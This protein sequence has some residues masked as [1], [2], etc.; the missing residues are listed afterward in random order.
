MNIESGFQPFSLI[1]LM[2]PL[3][4]YKEAYDKKREESLQLDETLGLL[5]N[6]LNSTKEPDSYNRVKSYIDNLSNWSDDFSKGMTMQNSSALYDLHRQYNKEIIPVQNAVA[7]LRELED[8]QREALLKDPSLFFER[9]PTTDISID[10]LKMNPNYDYGAV[11]SGNDIYNKAKDIYGAFSE[12]IRQNPGNWSKILEGQYFQTT[13]RTGA[14]L[15]EVMQA[16]C[17]KNVPDFL[18]APK[19]ELLKAYGIDRFKPADQDRILSEIISATPFALGDTSIETLKNEAWQPVL[20]QQEVPESPTAI[21]DTGE[22]RDLQKP[23]SYYYKTFLPGNSYSMNESNKPE[24]TNVCIERAFSGQG[25]DY[26]LLLESGKKLSDQ[27]RA[28]ISTIINNNKD[29]KTFRM[30][31]LPKLGMDPALL[32]RLVTAMNETLQSDKFSTDKIR[33]SYKR[34][35]VTDT[36]SIKL[37]TNRMGDKIYFYDLDNNGKMT[38]QAPKE[39][40]SKKDLQDNYDFVEIGYS[41]DGQS[42]AVWQDKNNNGKKVYTNPPSFS[43]EDTQYMGQL[44]QSISEANTKIKVLDTLIQKKQTNQEFTAQEKRSLDNYIKAANNM[45]DQINISLRSQGK[46]EYNHINY[47]NLS[48]KSIQELQAF[49]NQLA[50]LIALQQTAYHTTMVTAFSEDNPE[51]KK[52]NEPKESITL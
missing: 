13:K 15:K 39:P 27:D 25:N 17:Q 24:V 50:N 44:S 4:K 28:T 47:E 43:N 3:I 20:P 22:S 48:N 26:T 49:R 8:E 10:T 14:T 40:I 2:E 21:I 12:A 23:N 29:H 34:V 5:Q 11:V 35:Q 42:F 46:T 19:E 51:A 45:I 31:D 38:K 1:E 18:R 6:Q 32:Q 16:M 37:I 7:R 30:Q 33:S 41:T 52:Y 9:D 36:N